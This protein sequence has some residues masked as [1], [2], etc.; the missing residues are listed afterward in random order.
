MARQVNM[1]AEDTSRIILKNHTKQR[2]RQRNITMKH[3]VECLRQ[4]TCAGGDWP[5]QNPQGEW[6]CN[7]VRCVAGLDVQVAT[8]VI[9]DEKIIVVTV[10]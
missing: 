8:R 5:H 1:L 6:V 2:M 9:W 7:M 3:V 4:G 10:F